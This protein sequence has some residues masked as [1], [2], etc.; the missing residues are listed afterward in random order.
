MDDVSE[1]FGGVAR[2]YGR[3]GLARFLGAHV[4]VVGIGGVGSWTAEA[5][6]R[7]GIGRVTLVDLD[8]ICVTN[9]NRQIHA[10]EETVGQSKTEVMAR[11][12]R[13][14]SPGIR[15][16]AVTEFFHAENASRLLGLEAGTEAGRPDVVVDAIDAMANKVRLIALCHGHGIPVVVCGAAGGRRDPTRI[17]TSDLAEATHD[18]L[19]SEVRK[20]LR[21]EHGMAR[22][23]SRLGIPC[24]FSP[25]TQMY[26]DGE[27]GVCAERQSG[28]DQP[29]RLNCATGFGSAAVVTGTFG[30]AAA[31]LVFG[32]LC[33]AA[34]ASVPPPTS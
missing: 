4:M 3:A 28:P 7:T 10:L 6:A 21:K 5:L 22:D 19:L 1:R 16:D 31:A 9:V 32:S 8:E 34:E 33:P 30:F 2:L 18:R 15:V 11:R 23:G 14:I 26:P 27:G 24:V 20:R 29:M 13:S 12:L 25:E 17:R